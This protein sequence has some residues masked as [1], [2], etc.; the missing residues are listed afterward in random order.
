MSKALL[1]SE[2]GESDLESEVGVSQLREDG[3]L[4][5][6][7]RQLGD[8]LEPV[9]GPVFDRF[10][11]ALVSATQR[12]LRRRG[13][14]NSPPRF[15]GLEAAETWSDEALAEL[16]SDCYV[17][18]MQRIQTLHQHLKLKP[19]VDGLV[20]LNVK[21]FV[22]E[23]QKRC[24]P[25]GFRIFDITRAAVRQAIDQGTLRVVA[26]DPRIQNSTLLEPRRR[27]VLE[28]SPTLESPEAATP[29]EGTGPP[30]AHH[31]LRESCET[32]VDALIPE[33]L[34]A[35][36]RQRQAVA[37]RLAQALATLDSRDVGSLTF[38]VL[39]DGLKAAAR[40]RWKAVWV[41]D[42]G[43]EEP[44]EKGQPSG[45]YRSRP[46]SPSSA[47]VLQPLTFEDEDHFRVLTREVSEAV[48]SA[49]VTM[50]HRQHLTRLWEFLRTS[51]ADPGSATVPSRRRVAE[52]LDIPR[53]LLPEL[54]TQL[55]KI[56]EHCREQVQPPTP[57]RHSGRNL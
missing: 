32:W 28:G 13:L 4:T 54:Y 2:V 52:L 57:R 37:S 38:K 8:R 42:Q 1:R 9:S 47:I 22:Y 34:L 51:S 46:A 40:I 19:N 29:E 11:Q 25:L 26:G 16:V 18:L 7:V 33:L 48:E 31:L 36:G 21:H 10:W 24:D 23:R 17:F 56:I 44:V 15:V 50:P 20:L 6:Y 3:A 53:Y 12:E 43:W 14:W 49:G 35:H 27:T 45:G 41:Q 30:Q 5:A 39:V 55:G